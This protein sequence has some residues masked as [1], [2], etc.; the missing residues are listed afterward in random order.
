MGKLQ[1]GQDIEFKGEKIKSSDATYE[2]KGKI[3]GYV[4]DTEGC[5]NAEKI[6]EN[7][8]VAIMEATLIGAKE[9]KASEYKHMTAKQSAQ[10]ALQANPKRLILTHFSQR[11]KSVDELSDEA[12]EIFPETECAYDFMK[13][14]L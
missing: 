10:I 12:K 1:D 8:D 11:Y 6:I 9:D 5:L 14:K 4:A 13:I 2:V 3:I 7:A